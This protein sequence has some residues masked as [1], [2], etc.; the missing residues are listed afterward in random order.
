MLSTLL[1]PFSFGRVGGATVL[2]ALTLGFAGCKD[3]VD[4]APEIGVDYYPMAVGNYWTYA[5]TDSTWS[6]APP[7]PSTVA[8]ATY[9][10]KETVTGTFT[11]AAGQ[12]AYRMVRS[13]M[14]PP[15]TTFRDDSVF[16]VTANEQYVAINR[17]NTR[18]VELVFPVR[19]GR[20]WNFN[21]F[22]NNFNDTITAQTRQYSQVGQPYTTVA[23]GAQG[24]KT[25][26]QTLTTAN[27]GTATEN[28]LLKRISYQQVFAKSIG[29]VFRRR[30]YLAFYNFTN[31]QGNQVYP[32]NSYFNAFTRREILI[33]YGPK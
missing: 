5:V 8:A 4:V 7:T 26:P 28:S 30:V 13:K 1:T 23:V 25:Y 12:K 9:Q 27:T 22:N 33:D 24:A 17:N 18:T 14:V 21:A 15:A 10:F 11:D 6:P 20:T 2:T 32:A 29:P 16:V 31:S 19:Q 3:A